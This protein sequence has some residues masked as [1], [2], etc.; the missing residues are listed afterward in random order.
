MRPKANSLFTV[1][2]KMWVNC[3]AIIVSIIEAYVPQQMFQPKHTMNG[4]D[5][6]ESGKDNSTAH[7]RVLRTLLVSN[8]P[9]LEPLLR[10][11]IA[12][13]FRSEVDAHMGADRE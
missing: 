10:R 6:Q 11:N 3:R 12:G 2:P 7:M 4:Y 5:L 8:L 1:W 9:S 13:A